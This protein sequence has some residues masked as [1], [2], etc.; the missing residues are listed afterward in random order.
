[1]KL[2]NITC[3]FFFALTI[4]ICYCPFVRNYNYIKYYFAC[5]I[6]SGVQIENENR[7]AMKS[8]VF[9]PVVTRSSLP[10]V[11]V[12][13]F[14]CR[15]VVGARFCTCYAGNVWS[16]Q[17][18]QTWYVCSM[19]SFRFPNCAVCVLSC[20]ENASQIL[21]SCLFSDAKVRVI[22]VLQYLYSTIRFSIRQ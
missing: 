6:N 12:Y 15:P 13:F 18:S 22:H 7:C 21:I 9:V 3:S 11:N 10:D 2:T 5:R 20:E 8:F 17:L 19:C 1:M 16:L 14:N 4:I